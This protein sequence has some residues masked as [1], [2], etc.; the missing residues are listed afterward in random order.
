[1][2]I[3]DE[4]SMRYED[5]KIFDDFDFSGLYELQNAR[6][7]MIYGVLANVRFLAPRGSSSTSSPRGDLVD[8]LP[9][10]ST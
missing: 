6:N 10:A 1:M 9:R 8:G 2:R 7:S 5:S 3:F 4:N